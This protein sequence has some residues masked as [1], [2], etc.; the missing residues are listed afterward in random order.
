MTN[1]V[2]TCD[3]TND[4]VSTSDVKDE[5]FSSEIII[6]QFDENETTP[7]INE[8]DLINGRFDLRYFERFKNI[9]F[10]ISIYK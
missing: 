10:S 2:L 3:E 7:V 9:F 1:P 4:L 6:K 5:G 8:Y